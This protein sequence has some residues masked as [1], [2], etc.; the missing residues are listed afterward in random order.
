MSKAYLTDAAVKFSFVLMCAA[1][2]ASCAAGPQTLEL[3][4]GATSPLTPSVQ[5]ANVRAHDAETAAQIAANGALLYGSDNT[6]GD[7]GSYCH[8]S[9]RLANEG[10]F[11]QSVREASKAFFL[12]QTTGNS[13]AMAHAARDLAFAYS[14]AGDLSNAQNWSD[15]ALKYAKRSPAT[16]DTTP[17]VSQAHK[18][19]GDIALRRGLASKAIAAYEEA[20]KLGPDRVK[21]RAYASMANAEIATQ[22]FTRARDLF[23]HAK[24]VADTEVLPFIRRGEAALADVEGNHQEALRLYKEASAS[25]DDYSRVWAFRGAGTIHKRLNQTK[26]AAESYKQAIKL[27]SSLR[28]QFHS[29]EFKTGLFGQLHTVYDEATSLLV[30]NGNVVEALETSEQGRARAT[31]DLLR[32]R[33]KVSGAGTGKAV[34]DPMGGSETVANIRAALGDKQELLVFHVTSNRTFAWS[35]GKTTGVRMAKLPIGQTEIEKRVR[36]FRDLIQKRSP[37]AAVVGR[38]LY[39]SLVAPAKL[40]D[41]HDVIFVAHKSLHLLPF[42]ALRGPKGWLTEERGVGVIPSA[43]ALVALRSERPAGDAPLLAFGN[44]V[45]ADPP[46]PGAEQEVKKIASIVMHAET[47]YGKDATKARFMSQAP[48]SAM[49]HIAAHARVDD[50]D[51]MYSIVRL[52]STPGGGGDL[53]AH[54]VYDMRLSSTRMVVLSA[55]DSGG[56]RVSAGDEFWGFQRTFLGAGARTLL[57]THWPVFD[58]STSLL[59]ERFYT[60]LQKDIPIAALRKA[61]VDVMQNSKF[62]DPVHWASFMLVGLPG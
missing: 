47:F 46:L 52:A 45:S 34:V 40:T 58:D 35:L 57:L 7:W 62:S 19:L 10:N 17:V 31:L 39:A 6:K 4:T 22:N 24:A 30:D 36:R 49:I 33:V 21:T 2:L 53:E 14:L 32:G 1:L 41:G 15:A 37:E 9:H 27:A 56:G 54:E 13:F 44:P 48:G 25:G 3:S 26:E 18:I 11:R 42:Q 59:M 16:R 29:E 60:H 38:E 12:G 55:C 8:I 61:Q 28:G 23:R 50:L 43:S 20:I 51:P 5:L